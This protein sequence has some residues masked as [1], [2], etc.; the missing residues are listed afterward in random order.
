M[1]LDQWA[2]VGARSLSR[3]ARRMVTL[4]GSSWSFDRASN[5]L[6]E[7]C[8]IS[9]SDDTIERVCQEE[10]AR[11]QRWMSESKMPVQAFARAAGR[12]EFSTDGVKVNTTGGWREMRLSVLA[13]REPTPPLPAGA[14]G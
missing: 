7:F 4:A 9:V 2:G 1:P 12:A 13:R 5:H 8:H 10:G 3:G 11:A 6:K 14:M